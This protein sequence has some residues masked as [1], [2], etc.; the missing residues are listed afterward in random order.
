MKKRHRVGV[1]RRLTP[2][3]LPYQGYGMQTKGEYAATIKF[4]R[5]LRKAEETHG[6]D[7]DPGATER[8]LGAPIASNEYMGAMAALRGGLARQVGGTG[9][10]RLTDYGHEYLEQREEGP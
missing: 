10:L 3:V 4:L 2:D 9:P 5:A 6:R 8:F 1:G 7:P